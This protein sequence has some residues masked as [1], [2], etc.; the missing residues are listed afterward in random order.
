MIGGSGQESV[1]R[2]APACSGWANLLEGWL[3]VITEAA[4]LSAT[5]TVTFLLTD[6][7]GSTRHWEASP[8]RMRQALE[9]HDRLVSQTVAGQGGRV[10]TT[11]GEGD[12]FFA[13][14]P[15][16]SQAIAA[17]RLIQEGLAA[18]PWPEAARL[19]VRMA[20][21]SGEAGGDFRG[22]AAN[23]CARLRACG[24]GGQVL[25]SAASAELAQQSLPPGVRLLDLGKHRLRD[26][27]RQERIF[28]LVVPGLPASFPPLK[29]PR[30]D[31]NA[32]LDLLEQVRRYWVDT[33]LGQSLDR[34]AR[35]ELG[36]AE[37]PG[38]V[39][40]SLRAI[41]RRPHEP[42]RPLERGA[43]ISAIYRELGR[44]LL[45]LGEPGAGKTTML[46]ELAEQLLEAVEDPSTDPIPVVFH[47][48]SWAAERRS[49]TAWLVDELCKRYGVP[50]RLGQTWVSNDMVI[51][52]LDGLD[53]MEAQH[54]DACVAAIN[55]FHEEHGQL[56]LVVCSRV[57]EYEL[58]SKRLTL[59][60][61]VVIQGLTH[62]EVDQ[63]LGD[64]GRALADVRTVVSR[65]AQLAELLRTPLFLSISAI[66]YRGQQGSSLFGAGTLEERRQRLLADYVAVM[67]NRP[68]ASAGPHAYSSE[69]TRSW[70]TWLAEAMRAHHQSVLHVDWMQ[71]DWLPTRTQ[72]MLVTHGVTAAIV[73]IVALLVTLL[74]TLGLGPASWLPI[75][76]PMAWLVYGALYGLVAGSAAAGRTITPVQQ[77]RWSWAG[78]VR[79]LPSALVFGLGLGVIF[80]L[81]FA[82]CIGL[83]GLNFDDLASLGPFLAWSMA[84]GVASGLVG[85]LLVVLIGG[86]DTQVH[87]APGTP[88]E[89]MRSSRRTSLLSGLLGG[90]SVAL[91]VMVAEALGG[92]LAGR[93]GLVLW[94]EIEL[95]NRL[96]DGLSGGLTGAQV[97]MVLGLQVGIAVA[98][99]LGLRRGGAA[100]LRHL[101]LRWL[102]SRRRLVPWDYI[103]FLEH[104][105]G[106]ILLRRRGGGYEFMHRLLL[107]YFAS[108]SRRR[109]PERL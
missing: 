23:R 16:A 84:V 96:V 27:A 3:L 76:L 89:G 94:P 44:Q 1:R 108:V 48:S 20:L 78:V 49:L 15:T 5:A 34:V 8:D 104:A 81:I 10:L 43:P 64:A 92:A 25:L 77:S 11:H 109:G 91:G 41:L 17:A 19:Q 29:S 14:F 74:P 69:Q 2:G 79:A 67:L 75:E 47:L 103:A 46:L 55:S 66:T 86:R 37:R 9:L 30:A 7:Q 72:R 90:L 45:I 87:L 52:L 73:L 50:R 6:I 80:G 100:Y 40:N 39:D 101:S 54:R 35:I 31:E 105:T 107:E 65:D 70:L 24:H 97:G 83:S 32:R 13:V 33:E 88:G 36:L 99:G 51:P 42:D 60:G 59:R 98:L 22:R 71:P 82:F 61:A 93:S 95:G 56:P 85:G 28:Q 18:Q 12:S 57:D 58:L 53:E 102:L 4:P 26:L 63:Y 38:A 106:L 68:R 21:H 62:S